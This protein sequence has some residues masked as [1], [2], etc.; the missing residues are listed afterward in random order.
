MGY[1]VNYREIVDS[2]GWALVE[3]LRHGSDSG[4]VRF[5]RHYKVDIWT[6]LKSVH[7]NILGYVA[8]IPHEKRLIGCGFGNLDQCQYEGCIRTCARLHG[9]FV[10][11]EY[12]HH[13]IASNLTELRCRH[14]RESVGAD[15]VIWA[16]IQNGNYASARLF[17]KSLNGNRPQFLSKHLVTITVPTTPRAPKRNPLYHIAMAQDDE[18]PIIA[19]NLNQYYHSYNFFSPAS[20]GDI[21]EWLHN[22]PI[23]TGYRHYYV[24]KDHSGRL[25]AGAAL[26]ENFRLRSLKVS[27]P[28]HLKLLN[29]ITK[30]LPP[31]GLVNDVEVSKFWHLP[32][33]EAA[34]R[35]LWDTIRWKAACCA[36]TVMIA[37][38][39]SCPVIG[40]VIP[41]SLRASTVAFSVAVNSG[42][43][44]AS[45][46]LVYY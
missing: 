11:P 15:T 38:S 25:L 40:N 19:K 18:Y 42:V 28:S 2:D 39:R 46:R 6:S 5:S 26:A 36:N 43:K 32:G 45:R 16:A 13:G 7:G 27:L 21:Q 20:D 33:E 35:V 34:G 17:E 12:R 22:T 9:V 1:K 41:R 37:L 30:T 31:S 23:Q 14:I 4:H 44:M 8:E 29:L 3:L 10:H 24:V